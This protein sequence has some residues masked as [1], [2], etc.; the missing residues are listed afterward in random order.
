MKR[1]ILLFAVL[2]TVAV[3]NGAEKT[4]RIAV[5]TDLHVT[6]KNANDKKIDVAVDE[7][8][9]EKLD[10]VVID[11]D[12]TNF[13]L[14]K[15][16]ENV[17]KKLGRIRHRTILT[18]G[19]HE[20]TWSE[21]GYSTFEKYFGRKDHDAFSVGEYAFI[22]YAAGPYVKMGRQTISKSTYDFIER[23]LK[24]YRGKKIVVA[25][26]Y[27]LSKEVTNRERL[28]EL[29]AKYNVI[30]TING[31][32]HNMRLRNQN[33]CPSIVCRSLFLKRKNDFG[34]TLLELQGDS[35]SVYNKVLGEQKELFRKVH[36]RE[37]TFVSSL[38]G[39]A[40][41][42][43]T[44]PE[45]IGAKCLVKAG[46]L[47]HG[48]V[49]VKDDVLVYGNDLGE[50]AALNANDG[51]RLW[52]VKFKSPIYST[53][54]IC[55]DRVVLGTLDKGIVALDLKTGKRLWKLEAYKRCIG[56]A[57]YCGGYLYMGEQGRVLKIDTKK[58]EPVWTFRFA[59]EGQV[60]GAPAVEGD[61]VVFGSWDRN[62]YCINTNT[63]R[64]VWSWNNGKPSKFRAPGN[65]V[66]RISQGRVMIVAPDN[67]VTVLNLL[68]GEVL[69]RT[70]ARKVR[71]ATGMSE[72]R[73]LFLS[74]TMKG[75]GFAFKATQDSFQE[76]WST[77][78]G[79]KYDHTPCPVLVRGE[80]AFFSSC[81]GEVAVVDIKS[82]DCKAFA[83]LGN[84]AVN[85]F[86]KDNNGD[87]YLSL[88]EGA[89]YR[90]P[91]TR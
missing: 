48:G 80:D 22:S 67:H 64:K 43:A 51:K 63:G 87:V 4:F 3:L 34:Y 2:L 7:I 19:N 5:L 90:I 83:V 57:T 49:A 66:P 78:L 33:V 59:D 27:P 68:N 6:P 79:W 58:G 17:A 71:E 29:Y 25:T 16:L 85:A 45:A 74:K 86:C 42:P 70:A 82:G 73:T 54:T 11:G 52:T 40:E 81:D 8:N 41:Q 15:E 61:F 60:W 55:E 20:T 50:V 65:V 84:S 91:A 62:L 37:D 28:M 32:Y 56:A 35:V 10:L 9:G 76:V 31:H 12:V 53:P 46:E 26:H 21:S 23:S 89:I 36:F 13:G 14:D 75:E 30:F 24:K 88:T 77:P 44:D 18:S 47:I 1:Y 72:D 69:Y 38:K 39:I